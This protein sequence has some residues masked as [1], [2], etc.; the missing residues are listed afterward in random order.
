MDRNRT[1]I[2]A[3]L[4]GFGLAVGTFL[5]PASASADSPWDKAPPHHGS[6]TH[7]VTAAATGA[8]DSA[9]GDSS[10]D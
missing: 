2:A 1:R 6:V 10:W 3:L 8:T 9:P 7:S 4:T 5:A